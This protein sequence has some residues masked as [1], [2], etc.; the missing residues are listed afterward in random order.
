MSAPLPFS[1]CCRALFATIVAASFSA[2]PGLKS[3]EENTPT[4]RGI[5]KTP[6]PEWV[7]PLEV[8]PHR[9]PVNEAEVGDTFFPLLENQYDIAT[10]TNYYR[11]MK[12]LDGESALQEGAQL[13]FGFDPHYQKF[14]FHRLVIHRKGGKIDRLADQEFKVIQREQD[15]ERQLYDDSLSVLALLE[16]IRS[17]DVIEYA[18]SITGTN[19]VFEDQ[20]Y[21]TLTT[22][23]SVPVGVVHG[24]LRHPIDREPGIKRHHTDVVAETS[25]RDGMKAHRWLIEDPTPIPHEGGTPSHYDPWGWIEVST[26]RDWGEV[27]A[28]AERQH[29]IPDT[30]PADLAR[31]LELLDSLTDDEDRILGALRFAQDEIR[32]LGIFD[33]VHSHKPYPLETI[34]KR[35][36]GDCKDKTLLL[37]SILRQLGLEAWPALVHTDYGKAIEEWSASPHAFNHL[38]TVVR[39]GEKLYWLDPTA[40]YQR[41]PLETLFF[42]DYGMALVLNGVTNTDAR[43]TPITPQGYDATGTMVTEI[44]RL[45]DYRGPATLDVETVYHGDDADSMRSYFASMAKS[46]IQRK[47]V[48][49]YASSFDGIEAARDFAMNDDEK[50]NVVTVR[51]S[52]RIPAIWEDLRDDPNRVG[53]DFPSNY[54]K[55]RLRI[56]GTKNRTMPYSIG[57]PVNLVHR[58]AIHLPAPMN[59]KPVNVAIRDDAFH[60]DYQERY[61]GKINEVEIA[62]KS[63]KDVIPAERI[64]E[65]LT[66][67]R[68]AED[69]TSYSIWITRAMH[70]GKADQG[71]ESV[72]APWKPAWPVIVVA[73]FGLM[74][75]MLFCVIAFIWNPRWKPRRPY[76]PELDGIEGWLVLVAIG[77]CVQPFLMLGQLVMAI[78]DTNLTTWENVTTVDSVAYHVF[79][80]PIL[81]IETMITAGALPFS[82][83]LLVQFYRKHH[84]FPR[85]RILYQGVLSISQVV[86][87]MMMTQIE[88]LDGVEFAGTAMGAILN[89]V[90]F[91]VWTAYFL[92]SER[93][94][95]TFRNGLP[96]NLP[97]PLPVRLT[98]PPPTDTFPPAAASP[99]P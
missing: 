66:N 99:A 69:H 77:T 95:S 87:V 16:D 73:V 88:A 26:W 60:F 52:Y 56:P 63:V 80:A 45:P 48:N 85:Y 22:S 89:L 18:F 23:Y 14:A 30:L 36:F 3:Q 37:V 79:W 72:E 93:V 76:R 20:H 40:S 34:V 96:V 24:V 61:R 31:E 15:H 98:N 75:S 38:V 65:Y 12:R 5:A 50:G 2:A 58:I 62:Y 1:R 94:A 68:K 49:Y 97:P 91:G 10:R 29:V 57:L 44:Y 6:I 81:L 9:R 43:L 86:F 33:G 64:T 27:A 74:G 4:D 82:V 54:A 78:K 53:A 92:M 59:E 32:Y 41:G 46:E 17:G 42:P 13:T 28:W 70:E 47:Y 83:F 71:T 25:T 7:V 11:Y 90:L 19:P 67:V 55:E 51:E 84:T 39:Q 35:R 21:W 8:D